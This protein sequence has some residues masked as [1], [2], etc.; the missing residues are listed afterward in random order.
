[1]T[2]TT[3]KTDNAPAAI[4]P[5]SQGVG[6]SG[7]VFCSGQLPVAPDTGEVPVGIGA[8]TH[9]SLKNV[10]AVLAAGGASLD[11]V[12]K[13]TVFVKDL[14]Q[15]AEMNKVYASYFGENAPARS[16]VEVARLPKDVLVE[17]EAIAYVTSRA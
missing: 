12:V 7:L 14:G 5:Y 10:A 6:L 16:T 1:M 11:S 3:I 9:Q 17:I 13:T 2:H 8:Q 4:G 15:F